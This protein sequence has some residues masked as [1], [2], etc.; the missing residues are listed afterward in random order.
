MADTNKDFYFLEDGGEMSQL[1]RNRD[2]SK[3]PIGYPE[4][5]PQTLRTTISIMLN[6]PFPMFLFWGKKLKC[7]YNDAYRPSLG[8]NGKHPSI[9]GMSGKEAWPEIWEDIAPLLHSVT[10]KGESI[11]RENQL[12]P[13]F[14]N[15]RIED[16][17]WTFSYSPVKDESG[18]IAGVLTVCTDTTEAVKAANKLRESERRFREIADL[19]PIWIWITDAQVNVEYAN[20]E[21][22][23]YI[24][25]EK[26]SDFTGQTWEKMV[27][28]DDIQLVYDGFGE[29]VR[30]QENFALEYR[31]K[32][33]ST[34]QFEWFK[35]LAVP[36]YEDKQLKGFIGTAMNIEQQKS[37]ANNLKSEVE[38][39]TRELEDSNIQL[40]KMNKELQSFAYISSHDLQ[41]PLRKIQMFAEVLLDKEIDNLSKKGKD[42]FEKIQSAAN[43]MQ[44]LINDLL[45]YSRADTEK[46]I[47]KKIELQHI[48]DEVKNDLAEEFK[49]KNGQVIV[50]E[51]CSL[52]VVPFQFRQLMYNLVSNSLK[53]SK[54]DVAPII[55]IKGEIVNEL[56]ISGLVLKRN[57][58]YAKI[59]ITDN[60]IGFENQF[61]DKIFEVF[62]R[63]HGKQ[64]YVGTGVGLAI[65]KKIVQ[66]H[67]GY[68]SASGEPNVGS[69]FQIFI[70]EIHKG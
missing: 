52:E 36:R 20:K 5:W 47:F 1:M 11:W 39:R 22:L 2:W 30:K 68:I 63:L 16:V 32:N 14:R 34:D 33:A 69:V 4:T 66:N 58:Q 12:I 44:S 10:E 46:R 41:E 23:K 48:I 55:T 37:F 40:E 25:L 21:L 49:K 6:S 54:Q 26:S 29:A 43:R 65:V 70:P 57:T 27:H 38:V 3:T 64:E 51:S 62:Q 7:F 67:N 45:A 13:I 28:P 8:I 18:N 60:G 42:K 53:Y 19:S 59:T 24:G 9:L 15:G 17:Y 50:E 35:V 61:S 31:V 56:T